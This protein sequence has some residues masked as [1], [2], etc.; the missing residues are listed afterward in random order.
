MENSYCGKNCGFCITRSEGKCL[1]CRPEVH[2]PLHRSIY[3]PNT[4]KLEPSDLLSD[5]AMPQEQAIDKS[6]PALA[7]ELTDPDNIRF[8]RFCPIAICC[9]NK[10]I[11]GC[12]G[13]QKTFACE[14]YSKKSIM[15]TI[16][17]SKMEAWGMTDHGLK[18]AVP[19]LYILL[20]CLIIE[21]I[22]SVLSINPN[23]SVFFFFA[24]L[25]VT[26]IRAYAYYRLRSFNTDF[27]TVAA[28]TVAYI[29]STL[30]LKLLDTINYGVI[31]TILSLAAVIIQ[32]ASSILCYKIS[33]DAYAELV[34]PVDSVLESRW[35]KVWRITLIFY[36]IA[37]I[38]ALLSF[39]NLGLSGCTLCFGVA[40][41]ILNIIIFILM[42][43]TIKVCS[44]D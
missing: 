44:R 12:D 7:E 43:A 32:L 34:S 22:A 37:F 5:N 13:C 16:I 27:L 26:G 33:F 25:F 15:N 6:L 42:L 4:K 10:D 40:S 1:G 9:K 21:S 2:V 29:F 38:I 30:F 28:L 8:S 23:I 35:L 14:K 20:T 11:D 3:I 18:K 17:S 31:G 19:F 36:F 39:K 24:A 41:A